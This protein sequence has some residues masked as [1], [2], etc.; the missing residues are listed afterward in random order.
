MC[1]EPQVMEE[2][3]EIQADPLTIGKSLLVM[4]DF[5]YINW[6]VILQS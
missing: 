6:K 5:I 1:F 3:H 2:K 4:D